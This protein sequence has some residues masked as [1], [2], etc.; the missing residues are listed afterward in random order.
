MRIEEYL[1]AY[2][3]YRENLTAMAKIVEGQKGVGEEASPLRRDV[4]VMDFV[5]YENLEKEYVR[6]RYILGLA[7]KRLQRA[8][9]RISELRLS[10]YLTYKYLYFM[11][12]EEIAELCSY[13][14]RQVY[15]I[16]A[17]AKKELHKSLMQEIP[18]AKRSKRGKRYRQAYRRKGRAVSLRKYSHRR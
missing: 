11:T 17:K 8:I 6:K 3:K 7:T 1:S 15:R 13:C 2:S 9:S 5:D 10:N 18:R 14:P 16:A 12:N 4:G